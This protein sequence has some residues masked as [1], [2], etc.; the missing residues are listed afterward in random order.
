LNIF[1]EIL[2]SPVVL[3]YTKKWLMNYTM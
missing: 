3:K 1:K 2:M